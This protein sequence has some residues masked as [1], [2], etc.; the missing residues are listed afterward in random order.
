M[1]TL[2]IEELTALRVVVGYLGEREQFG[3][4]QSS[5]FSFSSSAF[6]S[7]VFPKTHNLARNVGVTRA[8]SLVH[9][10]SIGVGRVYHLFRLPEE[11]EQRVHRILQDQASWQTVTPHLVSKDAALAYLRSLADGSARAEAGPVRIGNIQALR[12]VSAW[13]VLA[14]AYLHAFQS[15]I[16]RYPYFSDVTS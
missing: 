9:D 8:A 7:P 10:E 2:L 13:P 1:K 4:W 15:G 5:F 6:L 16:Q 3:W 14:T 12:Q 11:I